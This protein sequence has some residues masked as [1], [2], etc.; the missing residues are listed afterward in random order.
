MAD[1]LPAL[2]DDSDDE[3]EDELQLYQAVQ[4]GLTLQHQQLQHQQLQHPPVPPSSASASSSSSLP[5]DLSI[6][7]SMGDGR[8]SLEPRPTP[9][10]PKVQRRMSTR[11]PSLNKC[12]SGDSASAKNTLSPDTLHELLEI[13]RTFP[14]PPTVMHDTQNTASNMIYNNKITDTAVKLVSGIGKFSKFLSSGKSSQTAPEVTP[15]PLH[16]SYSNPSL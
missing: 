10:R 13:M 12:G 14:A 11:V 1:F 6:D 3:D 9:I 15:S 8:D 5:Q 7:L 2:S 16:P 4:Q